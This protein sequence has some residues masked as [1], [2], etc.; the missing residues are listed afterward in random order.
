M[1][2]S[3][4]RH[5]THMDLDTFFVSVEC[6]RNPKLKGKPVLIGGMSDRGVVASCSYEARKFGI[7]S[8]MAMKIA[9]RLCS[10]AHVV[11]SDYEAY[12][13]YSR[14]VTDVIKD[15]VP[16]YEKASIDEFY[17]DLTGMDK[18]FGCLKYSDE[19]KKKI[20]KESGLS[21]SYALASNKLVSKVAT[22]EV[23]PNG[24]LEIPFG[25]E[26]TFLS[27][28]SIMKIP[29]I[30]KET[31]YRLLKMGVETVKTLSEIPVNMLYN[32]LGK[33]GIE[34]HRKANGIDETPV[35]PYREQKS[36]GTEE[37]FT[38]DTIDVKLLHQEL[39]RM[40]EKIAFELRSQEKL[41]GCV[42]VKI[43]Y[44]DFQTEQKQMTIDYTAFDDILI[45][46][47]KELFTGLYTKRQLIRLIGVRFTDLIS[48]THQI[49]MFN[50]SQEAIKLHQAM[51]SIKKQF[52]QQYLMRASA[53]MDNKNI[54][55]APKPYKT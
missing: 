29:G 20:V 28:L 52:G 30:G 26:K 25:N 8:G 21:I 43:R 31:G 24:Q 19:L 11:K 36:I 53:C 22:N 27:P 18:F 41:T 55:H 49:D 6:L 4:A 7:H 54:T 33:W 44:S 42:V 5:I 3:S 15:S 9:K 1:V 37:T 48:G 46:K 38:T 39:V 50:D 47:V 12:S 40:T 17:I 45:Q 14:L 34:L 10:H 32:L 13:K 2:L 35:I 51:D 16:L 23:K